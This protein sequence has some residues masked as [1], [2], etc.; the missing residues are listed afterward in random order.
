MAY[1]NKT[2]VAFDAD[3]DIRYYRLMTAWKQN[4]KTS[5]NFQN[6]HEVFSIWQHSSEQTIKR[7]LRERMKN[8]K[9]FILL[10]GERTKFLYKYVRWEIEQALSFNLPIIVV[11]LNGAKA[12]DEN[13][14]PPIL[15]NKLAI[16]ISF[17]SRIIQKALEDWSSSHY[18]NQKKGDDM[19]FY[20]FKSV[21]QS[22]G[23]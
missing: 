19:P 16:H 1:R 5:F 18:E 21:Y 12:M 13:L 2:Y 17:N 22:L 7:N 23:L 4:D 20:Y 11:N 8:T 14:C 3:N 15:R 10:V 9:V 6:V